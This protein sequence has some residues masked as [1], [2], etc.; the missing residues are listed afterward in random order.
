[1]TSRLIARHP[2]KPL[3][4]TRYES[5]NANGAEPYEQIKERTIT[6]LKKRLGLK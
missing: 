2:G 1:M 3:P 6:N 5:L 4:G